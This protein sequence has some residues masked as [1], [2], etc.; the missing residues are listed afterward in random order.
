MTRERIAAGPP[1]ALA[2][3]RLPAVLARGPDAGLPTGMTPLV[4]APRLA[5]ALGLRDVWVKNDTANPTHS[6]KDRV[7][8]VALEKAKQLGLR[9]RRLRLD[10]Q[11]RQLGRRPRLGARPRELRLRA[12]RPRGAEDRRDGGLRHHA[13]GRRRQLRRRQPALHGD[14]QRPPLGLRQRQRAPLLQRGLEDARLRGRRAARLDAPR[15]LHRPDRLG[16]ALHQDQP[17]L[18]RPDRR[19][20]WS[21]ARLPV[22]ERRP[23]RRL[24]PR[25]RRLRGRAR[26]RRAGPAPT[27]SPR[28]SRSATRPT[29]SSRSTSRARPAASIS[30]VTEEEIVEGIELLARTTGIFTETAGGVTTASLTKLA[31]RR[32]DRPGRARRRLH[33]RRRPQDPRRGRRR[34]SSATPSQPTVASFEA[35]IGEARLIA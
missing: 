27:R 10:R 3:P 23:G 19:P 35:A 1:L 13:D 11:P 9:G 30:A 34:A 29:A 22:L 32:G 25:G 26:L 2:L 24:R 14:R 15:P 8:S 21:R 16:L 31:A 28:A 17:R 5:E 33:H 6:F 4:R 7:V 18:P 20:A 12:G